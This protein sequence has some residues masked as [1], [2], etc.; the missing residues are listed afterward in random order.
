MVIESP[1]KLLVN[2]KTAL[3]FL[4]CWFGIANHCLIEE[5]LGLNQNP[6]NPQECA[7]PVHGDNESSGDTHSHGTPCDSSVIANRDGSGNFKSVS[8]GSAFSQLFIVSDVFLDRLIAA[9]NSEPIIH[10]DKVPLPKDDDFLSIH[11]APNAPP[12]LLS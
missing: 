4:L 12:T 8:A 6:S 9:S 2:R 7:I 3:L 1:M 10:F 5:V 11:S